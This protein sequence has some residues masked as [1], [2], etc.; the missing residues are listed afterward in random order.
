[1]ASAQSTTSKRR[2][3]AKGALT[4]ERIVSTAS[5]LMYVQGVE[6]TSLDDVIEAS[7]TGKSQMYH[8]FADKSELVGEVVHTQIERVIANQDPLLRRL[9]SMRGLERWRDAVVAGNR[10]RRGAHGCPL[11]S[12]SSELADYSEPARTA[13]STGFDAWESLFADGLGRMQEKGELD[14]D[15]DPAALARGL[16]AA[17]QGGLLLAQAKRDADSLAI[18]LDMALAHIRART[19][20]SA[21]RPRASRSDGENVPD[22][23]DH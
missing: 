11:G 7:G 5:D 15:A 21:S 17:L 9:D 23:T 19:T 3:T 16:M 2:L 14:D 18:A 10:S 4:R 6:R 20:P 12:L 13:L 1:M 22:T 8:Y